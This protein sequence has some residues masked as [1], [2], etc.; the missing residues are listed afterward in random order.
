MNPIFDVVARLTS[1]LSELDDII[2]MA[3]AAAAM[4]EKVRERAER[5]IANANAQRVRLTRLITTMRAAR[6]PRRH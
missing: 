3:M 2:A 5:L 4:N 1:L 6:R